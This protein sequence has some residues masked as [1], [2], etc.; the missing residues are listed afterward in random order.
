M[1]YLLASTPSVAHFS[2]SLKWPRNISLENITLEMQHNNDHH[3]ANCFS[4]KSY[5]AATVECFQF[6]LALK[7]CKLGRWWWVNKYLLLEDALEHYNSYRKREQR[8]GRN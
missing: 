6:I 7:L 2:I 3:I 4:W 8:H 1:L 5:S